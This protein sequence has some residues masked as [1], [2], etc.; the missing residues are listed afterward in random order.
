[1]TNQWEYQEKKNLPWCKW[2]WPTNLQIGLMSSWCNCDI[3]MGYPPFHWIGLRKNTTR[4]PLVWLENTHG[5]CSALLRWLRV[6]IH[7]AV[8]NQLVNGWFA[9]EFF[10]G[11]NS[12]I[13]YHSYVL[14]SLFW[15]GTVY[16]QAE[17]S[18]TMNETWS[19][20]YRRWKNTVQS[21][22][23]KHQEEMETQWYT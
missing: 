19:I 21:K 2:S 17:E 12:K 8:W 15:S 9:W 22:H 5:I 16:R 1:M 3:L 13:C 10:M 11:N 6:G 4:N 23:S 18:T 7:T 14:L 20:M